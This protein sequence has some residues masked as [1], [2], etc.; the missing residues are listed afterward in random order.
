MCAAAW[1]A[2][3]IA[4]SNASYRA[5]PVQISTP[6][7]QLAAYVDDPAS[8]L[9]PSVTTAPITAEGTAAAFDPLPAS[10]L[11]GAGGGAVKTKFMALSF[12]CAA[13]QSRLAPLL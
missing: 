4:P 12:E 5:P 11:A 10:A 1:Q 13:Q 6:A 3:G 8:G 2:S 9:L 7:F